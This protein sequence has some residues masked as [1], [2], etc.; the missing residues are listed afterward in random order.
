MGRQIGRLYQE[1]NIK[2]KKEV[3]KSYN[4]I[5]DARILAKQYAQSEK[6]DQRIFIRTIGRVE[7][8]SF[9]ATKDKKRGIEVIEYTE[10]NQGGDVLSDNGDGESV[11]IEEKPTKKAK[12]KVSQS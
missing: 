7:K 1:A 5:E 3:M 12:A 10:E 11:A 6:Q 8:F 2:L 4:T 9:C